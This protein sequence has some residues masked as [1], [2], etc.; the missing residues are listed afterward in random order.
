MEGYI[1][2][3]LFEKTVMPVTTLTKNLYVI[4][5]KETISKG[6]TIFHD[7]KIRQKETKTNK[8]K[9]ML[10]Q[11][12]GKRDVKLE[13]T[14]YVMAH[15]CLS[16]IIE[17][18]VLLHPLNTDIHGTYSDTLSLEVC[19]QFPSGITQGAY[20]KAQKNSKF[21]ENNTDTLT[22]YQKSGI[23][24]VIDIFIEIGRA[25]V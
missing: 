21:D 6:K 10:H 4:D 24:S 15:F 18:P 3:D 17:Y 13:N 1:I 14:L 23:N 19:G 12:A 20:G 16:G 7:Y 2:M 11:T 8:T 9:L 25:H 5:N 22:D